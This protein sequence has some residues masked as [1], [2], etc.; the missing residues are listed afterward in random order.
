MAACAWLSQ[1]REGVVKSMW[2]GLGGT[3]SWA[4]SGIK[5]SLYLYLPWARVQQAPGNRKG[6]L[7][8][9]PL[10]QG[11]LAGGGRESS[12]QGQTSS[13]LVMPRGM[14]IIRGF[15]QPDNKGRLTERIGYTT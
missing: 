12:F 3:A 8:P 13:R 10:F 15:S 11:N 4:W 5:Q 2:L 9:L 1:V 14:L 6:E 7:L